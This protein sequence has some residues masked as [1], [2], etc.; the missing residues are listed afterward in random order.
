M[1]DLEFF[2]DADK[3]KVTIGSVKIVDSSGSDPRI[4]GKLLQL[5]DITD[6]SRHLVVTFDLEG[7]LISIELGERCRSKRVKLLERNFNG[8]FYIYSGNCKNLRPNHKGVNYYY[9][10]YHE[11]VYND[12]ETAEVLVRSVTSLLKKI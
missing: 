5:R 2:R 10:Y 7:R 6:P 1:Q 9:D 12:L 3:R 4:L 8:D 11:E